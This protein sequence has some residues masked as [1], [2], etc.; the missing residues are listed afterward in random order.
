[1]I[2]PTA[3]SVERVDPG[4]FGLTILDLADRPVVDAGF[5]F[6]APE[7]TMPGIVQSR[8]ELFEGHGAYDAGKPA[9]REARN[10]VLPALPDE[11]QPR[12]PSHMDAK[13]VVAANLRSWMD[14]AKDRGEPAGSVKSL[15][16]LSGVSRPAI[17]AMRSGSGGCGVDTL[18]AVAG[19]FGL[20][21]WQMLVPKLAPPSRPVLANEAAI[22]FEVKR[23]TAALADMLR[24]ATEVLRVQPEQAGSARRSTADP[25]G[26]GAV[27]TIESGGDVPPVATRPSGAGRK[28]RPKAGARPKARNKA[29]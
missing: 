22:E 9:P 1:M 19:V 23:R 24:E 17:D 14:H 27:A 5:P 2:A 16:R 20:T 7:F 11:R 28:A 12:H 15:S 21:A 8:H 26:L 3:Q 29:A 13:D 6:N 4:V 25:F 10:A 18:E